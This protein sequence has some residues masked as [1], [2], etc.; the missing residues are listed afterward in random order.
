MEGSKGCT[1]CN[2]KGIDLSKSKIKEN[3]KESSYSNDPVINSR[4]GLIYYP[5]LMYD[6]GIYGY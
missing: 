2:I 4:G 1:G 3:I 6:G 5:I